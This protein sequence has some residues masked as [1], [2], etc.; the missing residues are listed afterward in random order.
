MIFVYILAKIE[1][2]KEDKILDSLKKTNQVSK[3]SLTYGIYDLCVEAQFKTMEALD[4]FVVNVL[5]K[6]PGIN[7]TVTLLTSRAVFTQ[8]G[9]A[10]SFG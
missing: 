5:R 7:E 10:I 2:G 8:S 6:I 3:A 1:A 9:H 4:N